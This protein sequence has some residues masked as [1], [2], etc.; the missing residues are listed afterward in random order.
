VSLLYV[1]VPDESALVI[2]RGEIIYDEDNE[3]CNKQ[4]S[5]REVAVNLSHALG[6]RVNTIRLTWDQLREWSDA[7]P[8]DYDYDDVKRTALLLAKRWRL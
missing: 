6:Q 4:T 2:L 8:E 7:T 1:T 5:A 3:F